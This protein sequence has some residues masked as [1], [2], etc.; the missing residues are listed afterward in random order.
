MLLL[1]L[2]LSKEK[3][4]K[5]GNLA[6]AMWQTPNPESQSQYDEVNKYLEAKIVCLSGGMSHHSIASI[7]GSHGATPRFQSGA[8]DQ[9]RAPPTVHCCPTQMARSRKAKRP[10]KTKTIRRDASLHPRSRNEKPEKPKQ[11][12]A[13]K[14]MNKEEGGRTENRKPKRQ[15]T[16]S[17]SEK[18]GSKTPKTQNNTARCIIA[19]AKPK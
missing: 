14:K 8:R 18:P 9:P 13:N 1:W 15:A 7:G 5:L 11:L 17:G 16:K 6:T 4:K 12:P 10:K 19:S 2:M 3:K